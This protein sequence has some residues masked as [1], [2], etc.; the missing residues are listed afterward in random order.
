MNTGFEKSDDHLITYSNG[1]ISSQI[2]DMMVRRSERGK[3]I[4]GKV[5]PGDQAV[6]KHRQA[7]A[8]I[9]TY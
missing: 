6:H 5:I 8:D 3:V 2:D 4:D 1:G 7:A 9:F